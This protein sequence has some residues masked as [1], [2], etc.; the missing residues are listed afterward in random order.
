MHFQTLFI[1]KYRAL[2]EKII[3]KKKHKKHCWIK[4]KN[5]Y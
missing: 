4:S 2:A 3:Q 5:K 1:I